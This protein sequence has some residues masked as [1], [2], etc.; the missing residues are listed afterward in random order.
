MGFA[1]VKLMIPCCRRIP[2]AEKVLEAVAAHGLRRDA[3]GLEIYVMCEIPNNVIQIDAFA[4][5]FDGFSIGLN[6]L[7]TGPG[8][9]SR[10]AHRGVRLR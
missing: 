4:R 6:D 2:E 7:T 3:N 5:L 8:G 10:L 1:N 9:R